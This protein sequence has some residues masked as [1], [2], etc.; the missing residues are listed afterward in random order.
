MKGLIVK[1]LLMLKN[2]FKM[3]GIFL[4]VYALL[5]IQGLFDFSFVLIF[6]IIFSFISTFSY[7][8]YNKWDMYAITLPNGRKNVVKAKYI[9]TLILITL[10]TIIAIP[11]SISLNFINDP[12]IN[13]FETSISIILTNLVM[14][15]IPTVLYPLIF[16]FGIEKA[17]ICFFVIFMILVFIGTIFF[18]TYNFESIN[19]YTEVLN[20]L[21]YVLLVLLFLFL[22]ISYLISQKI[23]LK[24]DF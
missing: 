2:N 10:T 7:D 11:L 20:I 4:I 22:F 5:A 14:L 13:I 16:K 9:T 23:Y 8:D 24:K 15:I 6:M 19:N 3:L 18:K 1:D 12:S 21:P 17:R